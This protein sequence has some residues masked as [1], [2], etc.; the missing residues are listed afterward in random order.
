MATG[1]T[2]HTGATGRRGLQGTPYGAPGT[3]FYSTSGRVNVSELPDNPTIY[4][5][6]LANVGSVYT[7]GGTFYSYPP[8]IGFPTNLTSDEYGAY[9]TITNTTANTGQ[10]I[11]IGRG[12]YKL[13][14]A[15]A[16]LTVGVG[17]IIRLATTQGSSTTFVF[18]AGSGSSAEYIAF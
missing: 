4:D 14:V 3:T 13:T 9:W 15:G 5:L 10:E 17:E 2:G 12:I 8:S 7:F 16:V 1:H 18:V 6:T 11:T